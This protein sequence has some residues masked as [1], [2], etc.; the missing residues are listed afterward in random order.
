VKGAALVAH[1]RQTAQQF[2]T[3]GMAQILR[4]RAARIA[5]VLAIVTVL[6]VGVSLA[7]SARADAVA[8]LRDA[9]GSDRAETSCGALHSSPVAEQVAEKINRSDNDW[10]DHTATQVPIADPLPGLKILGYRGNKAT[11]IQ[12]AGKT[13]VNAI[14]GVLLEGYDKIPDCSYTDYGANTLRNE[15]TG[16]YLASAVLAGA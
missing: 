10:L 5:S 3:T 9:L 15:R 8:D 6:A 14:K 7:P 2:A 1:Q 16:W 11:Q 12:G 4:R 13:E